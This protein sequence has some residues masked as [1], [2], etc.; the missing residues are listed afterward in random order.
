MPSSSSIPVLPRLLWALGVRR[1]LLSYV[2]ELGSCPL[3]PLLPALQCSFLTSCSQLLK[4]W[5]WCFLQRVYNFIG[6]GEHRLRSRKTHEL[7]VCPGTVVP[8]DET[9]GW[10]HIT[11]RVCPR[12]GPRTECP[13]ARGQTDGTWPAHPTLTVA[14]CLSRTDSKGLSNPAEVE[15]LREKVYASLEAYCKHKYPEQPGRSALPLPT[16]PAPFGSA[17]STRLA[18]PTSPWWPRPPSS[19]RTPSVAPPAFAT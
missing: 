3:L 4:P 18:L 7:T 10:H 12:A 6:V 5:A 11:K 16:R 15:A 14:S 9:P 8:G 17:H 13:A 19:G 2:H 1:Y